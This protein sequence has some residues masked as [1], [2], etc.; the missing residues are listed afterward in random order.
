[1][2]S[3]RDAPLGI[4]VACS[5][6]LLQDVALAGTANQAAIEVALGRALSADQASALRGSAEAR[7]GGHK[8]QSGGG[9]VLKIT[10]QR[11]SLDGSDSGADEFRLYIIISFDPSTGA[12][13][14]LILSADPQ[15][16]S[17]GGA[18]AAHGFISLR[19]EMP[20]Q[21]LDPNREQEL[22]RLICELCV[23][24]TSA[25]HDWSIHRPGS[26]GAAAKSSGPPVDPGRLAL[27]PLVAHAHAQG[28]AGGGKSDFVL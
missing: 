7:M 8:Q 27:C 12:E 10:A 25:L 1:M 6:S 19:G 18:D 4:K 9:N 22:L 13:R 2:R 26:I 17:Q 5:K 3:S 28:D 24:Q 14:R 23:C 16:S 11:G 15:L 20:A 21:L